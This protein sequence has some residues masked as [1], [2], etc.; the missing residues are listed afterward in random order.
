VC[1]QQHLNYSYKSLLYFSISHL[2]L[3]PKSAEFAP[4][5]VKN[6][7]KSILSVVFP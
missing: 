5:A 6:E 7:K 3:P 1:L 2:T 4:L